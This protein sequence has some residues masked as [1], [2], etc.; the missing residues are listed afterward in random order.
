MDTLQPLL[1]HLKVPVDK[2]CLISSMINMYGYLVLNIAFFPPG[3]AFF[4]R[5]GISTIGHV[6]NNHDFISP[7]GPYYFTDLA[8]PSFPG[9]CELHVDTS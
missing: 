8:Y 6:L 7:Y 5:T 2:V 3:G 1:A 4:N 9:D